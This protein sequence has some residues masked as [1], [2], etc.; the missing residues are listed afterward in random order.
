MSEYTLQDYK[1]EELS[2]HNPEKLVVG[3]S[4]Y[5]GDGS[6]F[7]IDNV[8][9]GLYDIWKN[10]PS[11]NVQVL[12]LSENVVRGKNTHVAF[13]GFDY[14]IFDGDNFYGC[15]DSRKYKEHTKNDLKGDMIKYGLYVDDDLYHEIYRI[16]VSEV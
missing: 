4:L 3:F 14:Y 9:K 13:T 11:D 7:S 15:N 8:T 6:V 10:A 1:D 16:A 5:Y 2:I 12:V